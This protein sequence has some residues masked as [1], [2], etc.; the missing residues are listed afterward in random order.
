MTD[1]ELKIEKEN[2]GKRKTVTT[3]FGQTALTYIN[4]K[5]SELMTG[6]PCRDLTGMKQLEWGAANEYEAAMELIKQTKIDFEIYGGSNNLFLPLNEYSGGSPD[7]LSK[8]HCAEIKCPYNSSI[9][10]SNLIASKK[11][12]SN[13]WMKEYRF[14]YYVQIQGNMMAANINHSRLLTNGLFVSF[15]PRMLDP[16][17]RLAIIWLENDDVIQQELKMRIDKAAELVSEAIEILT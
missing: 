14:D 2:K 12:L 4:E 10:I 3:T 8:E 7:A 1:E 6:I 11:G 9:H 13:I 15:D 5:I 17:N 16:K